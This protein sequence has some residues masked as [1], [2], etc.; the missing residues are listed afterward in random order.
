MVTK[1]NFINILKY[2]Y[3]F[4]EGKIPVAYARGNHEPRGEFAADLPA[5]FRT[6]T[7]SKTRL[8]PA[9]RTLF[10]SAATRSAA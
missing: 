5:C 1:D 3:L 2:T 8:S 10:T 4:S 7:G 6:T 9:V